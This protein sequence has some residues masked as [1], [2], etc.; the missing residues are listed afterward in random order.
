[1]CSY[2]VVGPTTWWSKDQAM[3]MWSSACHDGVGWRCKA[4][5]WSLRQRYMVGIFILHPRHY[6]GCGW[7][8]ILSRTMKR[9]NVVSILVLHVPLGDI[10]LNICIWTSLPYVLTWKWAK[11]CAKM[12]HM[13]GLAHMRIGQTRIKNKTWRSALDR[14]SDAGP[15]SIRHW[16][17]R[18]VYSPLRHA[19]ASVHRTRWCWS[20]RRRASASV[21]Y[22]VSS[23]ASRGDDR[24]GARLVTLRQTRQVRNQRDWELTGP[25]LVNVR[26]E[27]F[28][29]QTHLMVSK[30]TIGN[31]RCRT[32]GMH[33]SD[34]RVWWPRPVY[35][36]SIR[37]GTSIYMC[38]P[39]LGL[40]SWHFDI[41]MSI[42]S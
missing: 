42:L 28:K 26:R 15:M 38:W 22:G 36:G 34:R 27:G 25:R 23:F 20:D 21:A 13:L 4:K 2:D 19:Q 1:M 8:R 6:R 17:Q 37:R 31:S 3:V 33:P 24:R 11:I 16:H 9:G 10:S 18:L 12:F 40:L 5:S 39:A 29:R 35:N 7:L 30:S 32:R 41:L 14:A